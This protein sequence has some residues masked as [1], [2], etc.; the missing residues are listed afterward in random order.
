[1]K[2][3]WYLARIY[4]G[5]V[6]L[7]LIGLIT[8]IVAIEL[9]EEAGKLSAHAGAG[10]ALRLA[11]KEGLRQGYLLFPVACFFGVLIAGTSLARHGELMA[12]QAAGI[13]PSRLWVAFGVVTLLLTSLG[14]ACGELVVPET[15]KDRYELR[16]KELKRSGGRLNRFFN[17]RTQWYQ[18]GQLL[19]Y[20]PSVDAA[21]EVFNDPVIYRLKDGLIAEV[22]EAETLTHTG[23]TWELSNARRFSS[24]D[25]TVVAAAVLP[26][27]ITAAPRDLIDVTG[28]PRHMSTP[29]VIQ[30]IR[31]RERGGF[32]ATA[33]RIEIYT[34]YAHPLLA[35]WLY[36]LAVPWALDPDRRRSLAVTLGIGVIVIAIVLASSQVFRIL[37]LGHKISPLT[38]SWGLGFACLVALPFN[39]LLYRRYRVRGGL[40]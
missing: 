11:W 21:A 33:H 14:T 4:L 6:A 32:D 27:D 25:A 16:R 31:R 12:V 13:G 2:I 39:L 29:E 35:F 3:L 40:F 8:L 26:I 24:I 28:N 20:L 38:A 7:T 30:L 34:R 1:M 9:V 36:L 18:D 37:G 19:L 5:A 22:I 23:E 10:T 15:L 17:R